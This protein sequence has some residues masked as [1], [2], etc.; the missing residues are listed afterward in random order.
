MRD[1]GPEELRRVQRGLVD[2]RG[3]AF[4]LHALHDALDGARAEVVGV[5]LHRQAVDAYDRLRLALVDAVPYHLQYFVGDEAFAGTVGIH[6]GFDQVL[7]HVLVD[8]QR[9]LG[10]L[11]QAVAEAGAA[12]LESDAR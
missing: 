3:H 12:P 1:L 11:G 4:G 5:G 2:H 7:G 10:V 6:D 9:L 8:G